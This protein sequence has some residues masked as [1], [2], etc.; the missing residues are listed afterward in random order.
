MIKKIFD[1]FLWRPKVTTNQ[2]NTVYK[3]IFIH[4]SVFPLCLV[5]EFF[6]VPVVSF[7]QFFLI[8]EPE[9][10]EQ[11]WILEKWKSDPRSIFHLYLTWKFQE[12]LSCFFWVILPTKNWINKKERKN[13]HYYHNNVFCWTQHGNN[14]VLKL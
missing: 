4:R 3:H 11:E 1:Y 9:T 8:W 2:T 6:T 12:N 5:V 10:E 14:N 13:P 7:W